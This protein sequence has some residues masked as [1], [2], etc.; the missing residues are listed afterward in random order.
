MTSYIVLLLALFIPAHA[1]QHPILA[2]DTLPGL[3]TQY[4]SCPGAGGPPYCGPGSQPICWCTPDGAMC[5][6]MCK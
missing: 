3:T 1:K 2:A 6:W 5:T 4:D